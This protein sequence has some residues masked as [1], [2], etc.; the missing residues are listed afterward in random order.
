M[1]KKSVTFFVLLLVIHR[2][3]SS[4][5]RQSSP[6]HLTLWLLPLYPCSDWGFCLPLL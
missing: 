6:K 5:R 2:F 3:G 1:Q 4:F